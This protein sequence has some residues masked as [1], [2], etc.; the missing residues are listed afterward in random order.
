MNKFNYKKFYTLERFLR[1]FRKKIVTLIYRKLFNNYT[2]K[3]G[4]GSKFYVSNI[5]I[6]E[7]VVIGNNVIFSTELDSGF[8]K[9]GKNVQIDDK[10]MI[11]CSGGVI[12]EDNVHI[13]IGVTIYTH[14]HGD[15]PKNK[16]IGKKLIIKNGC[17][18]GEKTS[19]LQN[20]EVIEENNI[21][22]YGSLVTKSIKVK[23]SVFA[24]NP[25]KC[26]RKRYENV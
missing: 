8:I 1:F 23:D 2:L 13:S 7:N 16:P 9:I 11:D 19:I 22:G 21:I 14:D 6:G 25:L 10:V 5:E 18:I 4:Y 20:V 17:W 3:I 15:Y 26:I 12:I 24:G